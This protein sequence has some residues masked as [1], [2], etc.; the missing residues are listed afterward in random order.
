[1]KM[2]K[3]GFSALFVVCCFVLFWVCPSEA[4]GSVL[5]TA[6]DNL[7][8]ALKSKSELVA[9]NSGYMRVFYDGKKIGI[10]Y[11]DNHFNIQSRKSLDMELSI[12]GG[13]YAGS[14]AYYFV[15]G[16]DNADE[17]DLA[18]VIRVIKYDTNWN[19]VG[20]A[21]ITGNPDL[22]GGEVRYP[23]D[24]GCVEMAEHN[25]KLY[26]VTGHE[27]YIDPEY[28]QGHQGFL[29]IAVDTASM[30]GKI[31]DSD[32][33]HSFAQ[34]ITSKDSNLY[35][36]EQSEGSRNTKLS[37][38]NADNLDKTSISVLEYGGSRTSAWAIE[39]YASVDG[40]A[41]SSDHVLCLGTSID[42]SKYD[43]VSEDTAHNLYLTVT[44][45]SNFSEDATTVKWLTSYSGGGKCF[46]GTKITRVNDNRFMVSWEEA[47]TNPIADT[48]D[49]LSASILH[50]LF[51]DGE[52]NK[53]S[54]E[55]TEAAPISDCQPIVKGSQIVYCASN[56][57]MVNFYSI[58]AVTGEFH[59]KVY[60]VAGENAVWELKK[61]VLT[62]SGTG[63]MS[64]DSE[65]HYRYPV[66]SVSRVFYTSGDN[67]WK[68]IREKVKKI[69]VE[70]GITS[71][72]EGAFEYFNNLIEVEIKSGVKS[73][74][75]KAFYG[76]EALSKITIP[77]SV[78]SIG[79]DFLWTGLYW[80]HD[81]SDLHTQ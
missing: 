55:F 2:L 56:A 22:F 78:T 29:M 50:Y 19:K 51:I 39:C 61:G 31:V 52:G 17:S 64:I 73:I 44:P 43:S 4:A 15:E 21:K 48:G 70:S 32:L 63:A 5:P 77:S 26:I 16:Q 54:R 75:K 59:K 38:Y 11:Y 28:N 53:I 7:S 14:D 35:V 30:T 65:S 42:Q 69:V 71:I 45:M 79:E 67:G 57:T 9:T 13:F 80:T 40:M 10:E 47:D 58:N 46:L 23:F 72:P 24:Y 3:R 1:M 62:I 34:Y 60:R 12:W 41:V 66:S 25:G 36:L 37:K 49:G 81:D 27:G 18:E 76:C 33:W 20:T 6:S 8:I 74:G 68:S